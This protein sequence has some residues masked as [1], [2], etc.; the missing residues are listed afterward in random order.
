MRWRFKLDPNQTDE[1]ITLEGTALKYG[2]I[3]ASFSFIL[4]SKLK[5]IFN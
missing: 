4:T 2:S 3:L 1:E 5:E